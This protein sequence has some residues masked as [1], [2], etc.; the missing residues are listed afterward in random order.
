MLAVFLKELR[1]YFTTP[2]GYIFMGVF[3]LISG[4]LF[5]TSNIFAM[6]SD[7][8]SFLG[9][10][11]FIFLLVIPLLTMKILS[12]ERK[13]KTDQ[14]L[15]TVPIATGK[16]ITGKF[17]AAMALYL[18]TM[19]VTFLYPLF[20]SFHGKLDAAQIIGSYI[21]FFLLGASFISIGIF[22]SSLSDSQASA[23]ILTFCVLIITWIID[24]LGGFMPQSIASAVIFTLI[25]VIGGAAWMYSTTKNTPAAALVILAGMILIGLLY[26]INKEL[27]FNLIAKTFSWFSLTKRFSDFPM[28]ILKLDA[29]VYYVSFCGFFLFLTTQRLEKQRWS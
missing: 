3:L 22:V 8:S 9:S 13:Q 15:L 28:G 26:L 18:I 4:I 16:I 24:F 10:L 20:L 2:I 23:A 6:N 25:I 14:L 19:S 27:F 5:T 7:Y 12:E 1:T 11:V 29:I 17:L 21:G